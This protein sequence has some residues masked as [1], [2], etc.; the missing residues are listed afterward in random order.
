VDRGSF[1]GPADL[2][3]EL[4]GEADEEVLPA[5]GGDELGADRQA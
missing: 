1:V 2:L 3:L 5:V 4:G